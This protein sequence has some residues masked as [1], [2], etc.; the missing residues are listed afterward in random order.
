MPDKEVGR[1]DEEEEV[2]GGDEE[3]TLGRR[4]RRF[5][6]RRRKRG[7]GLLM[8]WVRPSSLLMCLFTLCYGGLCFLSY[9]DL[10]Q[11]FCKSLI[12]A[13]VISPKYWLRSFYFLRFTLVSTSHVSIIQRS[14][15]QAQK[16]RG[17]GLA[18]V[19]LDHDSNC[20]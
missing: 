14:I 18:E 19:L 12:N 6:R 5:L 17:G 20:S 9:L 4:M 3:E 1:A 10:H 15:C 11:N 2:G 7:P 16:G 8:V 13:I